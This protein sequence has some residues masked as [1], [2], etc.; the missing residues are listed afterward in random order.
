MTSHYKGMMKTTSLALL[1][2]VSPIVS[3]QDAK[4]DFVVH[5]WGTF[6]TVAGAD[7]TS[8]D[9]SPLAVSELPGFVYTLEGTADG[10][11]LRALSGDECPGCLHD[12]CSCGDK[13]VPIDGDGCKG[14]G[15]CP[16]H[17]AKMRMETPVIYFYAGREMD[18]RVKVDFPKGLITE[19]Y[20]AVLNVKPIVRK[21]L[22][23]ASR[24]GGMLDWGTFKIFPAT[25]RKTLITEKDA[26]HYYAARE[27]DADYVRVCTA[28]S[29][30]DAKTPPELEKF[31]FYRGIGDFPMPVSATS[32]GD[33]I[34]AFTA[35]DDFKHAFVLQFKGDRARFGD[36][37]GPRKEITD[38]VISALTKALVAEGLYQKEAD[39]M[40]ETWR[41]SYFEDGARVLYIVPR[42]IVDEF[43]PLAVTPTPDKTV[44]VFVGRLECLTPEREQAVC[45]LIEKLGSD[46]P[47]ARE[48]AE[49]A[50]LK[51]GRFAQPIV[52]RTLK[53]RPDPEVRARLERLLA[54][55][56]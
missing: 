7:G 56:R 8:L 19:W 53:A 15:K 32:K 47:A 6:T 25:Q 9:W 2:L 11:G 12:D 40:I 20:P 44:R 42:R 3:A 50:I 13:C 28:R 55:L 41:D 29:E 52:L 26:S 35:P 48:A 36:L 38:K 24:T 31:L 17:P 46:D 54:T 43:L 14:G 34:D 45:D 37:E 18:V 23:L 10:K 4:K 30:A 33:R 49:C 16:C 1:L 27:T 21:Q 39:A 22:P 5:E 51:I